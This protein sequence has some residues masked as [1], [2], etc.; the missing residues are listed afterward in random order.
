MDIWLEACG[1]SCRSLW[2]GRQVSNSRSDEGP[3]DTDL[4][5]FRN[6]GV[7]DC[8]WFKLELNSSVLLKLPLASSFQL[9]PITLKSTLDQSDLPKVKHKYVV[10]FLKLKECSVVSFLKSYK[11]KQFFCPFP[12]HPVK[13]FIRSDYRQEIFKIPLHGVCWKIFCFVFCK[14]CS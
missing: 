13:S 10:S 6:A 14:Q 7:L 4:W 12:F 5:T 2:Q 11:F 1:Q 8:H 3:T 9:L